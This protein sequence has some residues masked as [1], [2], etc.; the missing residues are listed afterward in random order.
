MRASYKK[1]WRED[2]AEAKTFLSGRVF[3]A[4]SKTAHAITENLH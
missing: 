4:L 1:N 2:E 3:L